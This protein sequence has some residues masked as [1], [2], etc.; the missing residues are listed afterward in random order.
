[1]VG[2]QNRERDRGNR[3]RERE[4]ERMRKRVSPY[5]LLQGYLPMT[6]RPPT[7]LYLLQ[8]LLPPH[9]TILGTRIFHVGLLWDICH[10]NY[11]TWLVPESN[12]CYLGTREGRRKA[13]TSGRP[14]WTILKAWNSI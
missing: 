6:Y 7:G 10:Q 8:V 3:E 11:G 2:K 9:K 13:T 12:H 5:Y 1:M 4:R 14:T